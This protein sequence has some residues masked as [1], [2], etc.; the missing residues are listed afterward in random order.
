[1]PENGYGARMVRTVHKRLRAVTAAASS[2][3]RQLNAF[4]C[5]A[6]QSRDALDM[7]N[8]CGQGTKQTSGI[9]THR[10]RLAPAALAA[11]KRKR[12]AN[13]NANAMQTQIPK[14]S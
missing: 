11:H 4:T 6:G 1:M 2:V 9:G 5:G 10:S 14:R 3:L 13:A 12:N 7:S 8:A